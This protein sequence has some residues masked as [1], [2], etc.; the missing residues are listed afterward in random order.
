MKRTWSALVALTIVAG[1]AS[2]CGSSD[3]LPESAAADLQ[4]RVTEIRGLAE[5]RQPEQAAGRLA[6]LRAAVATLVEQGEVDRGQADEILAAASS[7]EQQLALITTTTTS[8]T[9]APPPPP[10]TTT[11]PARP[12]D[13]GKK[14]EDGKDDEKDQDS[15]GG[16]GRD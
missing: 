13:D 15:R 11:A 9:T 1:L 4:G 16:K 7:V 12:S 14:G 5:S 2:S 6:E 8:T 3:S 10:P